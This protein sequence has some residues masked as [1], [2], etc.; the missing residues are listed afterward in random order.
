MKRQLSSIVTFW[1]A[2]K[3]SEIEKQCRS[4]SEEQSNHYPVND[5]FNNDAG[6]R[7][8]PTVR[9][10][11]WSGLVL[12]TSVGDAHSVPRELTRCDWF[13]DENH[14]ERRFT[15]SRKEN[16]HELTS[17]QLLRRQFHVTSH[18]GRPNAKP[19]PRQAVVTKEKRKWTCGH[20]D[21]N[22]V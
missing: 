22:K 11:D 10:V 3:A 15:I 6:G 5:F 17:Q 14:E 1:G 8:R 18:M 2:K 20:P 13:R 16:L 9:V 21:A 12:I 7:G 4:G 19:N